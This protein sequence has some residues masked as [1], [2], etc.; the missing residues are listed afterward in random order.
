MSTAPSRFD[1]ETKRNL[2]SIIVAV[3]GGVALIIGSIVGGRGTVVILENHVLQ[4]ENAALQ[5]SQSDYE[6]IKGENA[7]LRENLTE[8]QSTLSD[9]RE[10]VNELRKDVSEK[11]DAYTALEQSYQQLQESYQALQSG[12]ATQNNATQTKTPSNATTLPTGKPDAWVSSMEYF[13]KNGNWDFGGTI[14]DN[15][16]EERRHSLIEWQSFMANDAYL[17]YRLGGAYSR[18]TGVLFRTYTYREYSGQQKL[19]IYGDDELLWDGKVSNGVE[20]K[21]FDVDV[22]GVSQLKLVLDGNSGYEYSGVG[23]VA[24]WK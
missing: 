10:S 12:A 22:S 6:E 13:D 21:I 1:S 20:P 3:I 9:L 16:G 23:E 18:L 7:A 5:E 14:K 4:Q 8:M 24:L 11:N 15:I 19:S 2:V 17:T